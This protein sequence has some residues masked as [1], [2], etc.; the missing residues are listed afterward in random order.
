MMRSLLIGVFALGA[1]LP[2]KVAAADPHRPMSTMNTGGTSMG[3]ATGMAGACMK[4]GR[5]GGMCR[6]MGC[7]QSTTAARTIVVPKLPPGNEKLQLEMDADINL[8]VAEIVRK[9]VAKIR[10]R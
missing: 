1:V 3:G 2:L 5:Q 4:G 10:Q 6:M 7:M 9:Y 8:R